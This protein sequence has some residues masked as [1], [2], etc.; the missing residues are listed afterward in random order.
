MK[1]SYSNSGW[2]ERIKM[3]KSMKMQNI[4][5]VNEQVTRVRKNFT[6]HY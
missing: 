2:E 3:E 5:K 6:E 1:V 4:Y